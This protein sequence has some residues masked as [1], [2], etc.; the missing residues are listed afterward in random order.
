MHPNRELEV[1][2][3]LGVPACELT[4]VMRRAEFQP[5]LCS[6]G[7]SPWHRAWAACPEGSLSLVYAKCALHCHGC[8]LI[9]CLCPEEGPFP[10]EEESLKC[11][12]SL[13]VGWLQPPL[14]YQGQ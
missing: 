2:T 11:T 14:L 10:I 7:L 3:E 12:Q 5:G 6:L 13:P 8:M 4:K 9:S 1:C